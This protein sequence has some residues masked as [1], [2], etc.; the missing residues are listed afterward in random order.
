MILDHAINGA[1]GERT[2]Q[3]SLIALV[4]K[5]GRRFV[6][7]DG[8]GTTAPRTLLIRLFQSLLDRRSPD[9]PLQFKGLEDLPIVRRDLL[10]RGHFQGILKE[11]IHEPLVEVLSLTALP[12]ADRNTGPV[13]RVLRIAVMGSRDQHVL[14]RKREL[15]EKSPYLSLKI[16]D[17]RLG[18]KTRKRG[19]GK[20]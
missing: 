2:L 19:W 10:D 17:S 3:T 18:S 20:G 7:R 4:L 15:M 14:S 11:E 12:P 13:C 9:G 8:S 5:C 1:F 16:A 6:P